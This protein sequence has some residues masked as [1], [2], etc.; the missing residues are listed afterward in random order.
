MKK[1]IL[2]ALAVL[3]VLGLAG[4]SGT[5]HDYV[6]P[7]PSG[8]WFYVD[9]DPTLDRVIFNKSGAQTGNLTIDV[10][11]GS[12]YYTLSAFDSVTEFTGANK[13]ASQAGRIW[14]VSTLETFDV[15][16][17]KDGGDA[18]NADWPGVAAT[19]SEFVLEN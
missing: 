9:V 7:P 10:S 3:M 18:K 8:Y 2:T 11:S 15:Y 12:V 14:V 4:C 13:P 1:I 16:S 17:W 19:K 5:L 6:D